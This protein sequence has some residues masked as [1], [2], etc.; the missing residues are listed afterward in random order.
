MKKMQILRGIL[1]LLITGC[2]CGGSMQVLGYM[3]PEDQLKETGSWGDVYHTISVTVNSNYSVTIQVKIL[4]GSPE[5]F[6]NYNWVEIMKIEDQSSPNN[7]KIPVLHWQT[8]EF[9][10][11][12][13]YP[14][15]ADTVEIEYGENRESELVNGEG[16]P[17][18]PG[19]YYVTVAGYAEKGRYVVHEPVYFEIP[20]PNATRAP[21]PVTPAPK[22][23]AA[24]TTVPTQHPT[25]KPTPATAKPTVALTEAPAAPSETSE[26]GSGKRIF[27]ICIGA[28]A[29]VAVG[30]IAFIT[31]RKRRGR[32]K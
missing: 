17:L 22:P 28:A 16:S 7:D 19:K 23:T 18:K 10:C 26:N 27:W 20:D 32:G 12:V 15:D 2:I 30:I 29:V 13:T 9:G 6:L 11:T 1:C 25:A 21:V 31:V 24:P 5:N 8:T 4:E 3:L 14:D